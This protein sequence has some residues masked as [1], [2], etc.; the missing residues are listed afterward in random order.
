M[1]RFIGKIVLFSLLI[2]VLLLFGISRITVRW[3]GDY[4][5]ALIDKF[6]NLK[7]EKSPKIVLVGGS[8]LAFGMDSKTIS[9]YYNMPVINMGLHAGI[10]LH[11]LLEGIKPYVKKDDIILIIPEYSHFYDTY[12]GASS[13]LIPVL[14]YY[15]SARISIFDNTAIFNNVIKSSKI[16]N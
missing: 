9:E 11:F 4:M 8:N 10:G 14:S 6:D 1:K 5:F 2:A 15:L 7:A 3:Q 16:F 13:D 12:L